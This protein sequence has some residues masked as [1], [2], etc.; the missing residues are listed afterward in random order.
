MQNFPREI[1]IF[2][3]IADIQ[4]AGA[5]G[6]ALIII[7][8]MGAGAA[9]I[10]ALE[11]GIRRVIPVA[12]AA[13]ALRLREIL[14]GENVLL[15]GEE[16]GQI[17]EGFDVG[18]VIP[19]SAREK[20]AGKEM[21]LYSGELAELELVRAIAADIYIGCFNN[22]KAVVEKIERSSRIIIL[23]AGRFGKFSIADSVC[24]GMLIDRLLQDND[25]ERGLNDAAVTARYLYQKNKG[26]I[27]DLLPETERGRLLIKRGAEGELANLSRVDISITTPVYKAEDRFFVD[28]RC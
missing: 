7:D 5:G 21:V 26:R 10:A 23:C 24:A 16:D 20:I 12:A 4:A 18:Y 9:V 14:G 15:C 28:D 2:Y 6:G 1:S 8:V 22:M 3:S 13:E 25:D 19:E 27:R 11:S 17:I